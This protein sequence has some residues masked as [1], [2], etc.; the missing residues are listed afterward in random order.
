MS[1]EE[2]IAKAK[3]GRVDFNGNV[4]VNGNWWPEE[5]DYEPMFVHYADKDG[6]HACEEGEEKYLDCIAPFDFDEIEDEI[7]TQL[8]NDIINN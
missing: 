7:Y 5:M 3:A 8:I 1:K 2:L 4:I 6:I